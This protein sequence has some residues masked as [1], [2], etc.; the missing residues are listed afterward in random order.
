MSIVTNSGWS[1]GDNSVADSLFSSA[2]AAVGAALCGIAVYGFTDKK[3]DIIS[4]LA[5][6]TLPAISA[7]FIGSLCGRV[8]QKLIPED[9]IKRTCIGGIAGVALSIGVGGWISDVTSSSMWT[10]SYLLAPG[11]V[12]SSIA[13]GCTKT[14]AAALLSAGTGSTLGWCLGGIASNLITQA[15]PGLAI[16]CGIFGSLAC[17][18]HLPVMLHKKNE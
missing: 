4:D 5:V 13:G 8:V 10:I 2:S 12:A 6:A 9:T 3:T 16:Y 7:S 18:G 11:V 1:W 14:G 15:K 17:L